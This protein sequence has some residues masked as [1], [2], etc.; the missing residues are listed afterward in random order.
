M[1]G[2]KRNICLYFLFKIAEV[3]FKI[4]III[5]II[6]IKAIVDFIK[7]N[8]KREEKVRYMLSP[9]IYH[10]LRKEDKIPLIFLH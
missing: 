4:I 10:V 3:Y 6:I 1:W 5:I 8:L 7:N 9:G 2:E